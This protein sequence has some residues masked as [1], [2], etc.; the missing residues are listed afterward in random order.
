ME[1]ADILGSIRRHL[2]IAV[3]ILIIAVI[4]LVAFLVTRQTVLPP[5]RYEATV[6]IL[7]PARDADGVRPEGVP[8]ILLQGQVSLAQKDTTK[9]DANQRG[10]FDADQRDDIRYRAVL[11]EAGD[12]MTV[13]ASAR[14]EDTAQKAADAYADAFIG[15]R[16]KT[17]ADTTASAQG[18]ARSS[19]V[20]LND[21]L[22]EIEKELRDQNIE[23]PD[24]VR[25]STDGDGNSVPTVIDTQGLNLDQTLLVYSRNSIINQIL[26]TRQTYAQLEADR[27][28]PR[29]YTDVVEK[30][31][32]QTITPEPPSPL[33]PIA[34]ALGGGL[35][36]PGRPGA[37]GPLRPHH[38]GRPHRVHHP[39]RTGARRH[40]RG[41]AATTA[42]SRRRAPSSTAPTGRSRPRAW[43]R[44][45]CRTL[46]VSSP[47]GTPQDAVAACFAVALAEIGVRVVLV[48]TN[49]N[50][51]WY[52]GARGDDE[53]AGTHL[54]TCWSAP[55]TATSTPR[56]S[57]A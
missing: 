1:L 11:N 37:D 52:T 6:Q 44:T 50:H 46:L 21:Q 13:A 20:T 49:A 51:D 5:K 27:L 29:S 47:D 23:L 10:E 28:T 39:G 48:G 33:I 35:P 56:S 7:I 9:D 42:P 34:V 31:A 26:R 22:R 8:P 15:A 54:P 19:L 55:T 24:V 38:Q 12:I 30:P 41:P 18:G 4:L 40:P 45:D 2:R 14:Q 36:R 53:L 57:G 17:V 3:G 25:E 32:P 43:P 16:R